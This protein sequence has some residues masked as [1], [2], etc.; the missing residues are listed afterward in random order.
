MDSQNTLHTAENQKRTNRLPSFVLLHA[1]LL[2]YSIAAVFSKNAAQYEFIS[3]GFVLWYSGMIALLGLY[4]IGWQQVL[5]RLPLTTAYVNK[6]I[7]IIW[8]FLWGVLLFDELISIKML[9]GAAIIIAGLT[10]V[11]TSNE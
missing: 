11:V 2:V 3:L 6:G 4:A 9:I 7:T 1:M 8:G 10:L 5:K